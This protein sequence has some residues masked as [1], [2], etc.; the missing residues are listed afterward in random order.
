MA[1]TYVSVNDPLA[2]Q[3][4]GRSL[5]HEAVRATSFWKF[6]GREATALCQVRDELTKGAGDRITFGLRTRL[7]G[8]GIS[9]DGEL[10]GNEEELLRYADRIHIDQL[11][12]GVRV[13]GNMSQQR[14]PWDIRAEG[15]SALET[16]WSE[17]MDA[18]F[19]NQLAG[20]TAQNG[21]SALP[22]P[23]N[24]VGM[25]AAI[26]PSSTRQIF[27]DAFNDG[28]YDATQTALNVTEA[29]MGAYAKVATQECPFRLELID[30]CVARARTYGPPIRPLKMQGMDPY[31]IFV[32][33]YQ[34][35]QM[36]QNSTAGQWLDISRAA[37]AGGMVSRNPIFTGADGM[38][39]NTVIHQ[40]ARVPWGD[41]T[42]V[43][44][45]TFTDLGPNTSDRANNVGRAIFCGA[46]ALCLSFGRAYGLEGSKVR[47][48]WT[49]IYK[50]YENKL[51]IGTALVWG[52]KKA[53][54]QQKDF[55]TIVVSTYSPAA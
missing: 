26:A 7:Q 43:G 28:A 8:R 42:Q 17:I 38:H 46:Q 48:K 47:F 34:A 10:D 50:D 51:G 24:V 1:D 23:Y 52:M 27:A 49:E 9:G 36:R 5:F 39:N 25:Q 55:A 41:N 11:R 54:F 45:E 19:F 22:E 16:W 13:K 35:L 12:W 33:P 44:T 53:R 29:A 15:Q 21:D 31:C 30:R 32:H 40:S 14:V 2:T 37:M 3:V 20:N 6:H 18:G 4:W